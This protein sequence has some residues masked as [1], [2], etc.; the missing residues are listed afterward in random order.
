[1]I[2]RLAQNGCLLHRL[3]KNRENP[4]INVTEK[5]VN[6]TNVDKVKI[7]RDVASGMLHLASKKVLMMLKSST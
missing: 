2:V 1:M 3:K 6:F 5:N 7:A 4:Y